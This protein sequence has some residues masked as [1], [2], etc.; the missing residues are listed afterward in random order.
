MPDYK[1]IHGK[2]IQH[3]ASDLDSTEAEGQIWFNTTSS[4]FKTITKVA[5][6]WA[7]GNS[8]NTA[9]YT[10]GGCGLQA[11]AIFFG[12]APHP[13]GVTETYDGISWTEVADLNEARMHPGAAGTQTAALAFGGENPCTSNLVSS[14]NPP[15]FGD[16]I[17]KSFFFA[18]SNKSVSIYF[19]VEKLLTMN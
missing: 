12:G 5:G 8:L 18:K 19:D 14:V 9:R 2:N 7:T 10:H 1:T 16:S 13:K 3:V 6:T 15:L 11:A 17:I 4:D